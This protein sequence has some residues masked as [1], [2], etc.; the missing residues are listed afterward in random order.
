MKRLLL[1]AAGLAILSTLGGVGFLE[2]SH[3]HAQ[4]FIDFE[5]GVD[6]EPIQSSIPGLQF[7]TTEGYDWIYGD[8]RT[9]RYNGP[10]PDGAYYSNGNFFAW[11]G[12]NQGA[13]RIDLTQSCATY[14]QV[15]VSSAYGLTANAYRSNGTLAATASVEGNLATG[16]LVPLRVEVPPHDC[17]SYVILHDTGNQWMIDDLTTDAPGSPPSRH[18]PPWAHGQPP[19]QLRRLSR[20]YR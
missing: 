4:G 18:H 12:P 8:W 14:L 9:G 1:I 13:G 10:Y 6:G 5:D 16:R 11:L 20:Q 7:T 15:W 17:F 2:P 3:V 19:E